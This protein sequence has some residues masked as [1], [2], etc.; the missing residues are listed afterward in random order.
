MNLI[1]CLSLHLHQGSQIKLRLASVYECFYHFLKCTITLFFC[2]NYWTVYKKTETVKSPA[3][4]EVP[5]GLLGPENKSDRVYAGCGHSLL[6]KS[7]WGD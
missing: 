3:L 6:A 1:L 4:C 2:D 5:D 7:E